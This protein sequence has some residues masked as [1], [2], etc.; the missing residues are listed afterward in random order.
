MR[1]YTSQGRCCAAPRAFQRAFRCTRCAKI[2]ALGMYDDAAEAHGARLS[3][4]HST[5]TGT[6]QRR[7]TA[8]AENA[9][10][11]AT[12]YCVTRGS[13]PHNRLPG[14]ACLEERSRRLSSEGRPGHRPIRRVL[15]ARRRPLFSCTNHGGLV[16]F[17]VTLGQPVAEA[18]S[19][20]VCARR[21]GTP[22]T[23]PARDPPRP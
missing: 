21:P 12:E 6:L 16:D 4:G 22:A 13:L 7:C 17:N 20:H 14:N 23:S 1:T 2:D 10:E 8:H 11:T 5:E 3:S 9:R 19:M 18:T 15:L